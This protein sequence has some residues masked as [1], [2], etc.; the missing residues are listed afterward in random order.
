ML[1]HVC[2]SKPPVVTFIYYFFNYFNI[3]GWILCI[4][5]SGNMA[6]WLLLVLGLYNKD[7][8]VLQFIS[9]L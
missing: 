9:I 1:T 6:L 5:V 8:F 4:A 7:F 2:L 3:I